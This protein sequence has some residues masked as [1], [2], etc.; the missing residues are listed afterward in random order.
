MLQ[1]LMQTKL[2]RVRVTEADLDHEASCGS[3]EPSRE[4]SGIAECAAHRP[5][6]AHAD[7]HDRPK[8]LAVEIRADS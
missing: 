3:E 8:P 2:H 6:A 7:E 1:A 5:H 4:T